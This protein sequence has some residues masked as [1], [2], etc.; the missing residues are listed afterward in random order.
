ML[1]VA[2][3]HTATL[4][5]TL[6]G[7]FERT[8]LTATVFLSL[9]DAWM[10]LYAIGLGTAVE[11]NPL[12]AALIAVSPLVFV[13]GKLSLLVPGMLLLYHHRDRWLAAVSLRLAFLL[14]LSLAAYHLGLGR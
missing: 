9:L 12:M 10:T 11:L 5:V 2:M 13:A 6:D 4:S 8:I 14:H 3:S 1:M 7:V